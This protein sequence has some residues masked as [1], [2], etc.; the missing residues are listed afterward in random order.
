MTE[1]SPFSDGILL[2]F[3]DEICV[4]PP[5][6]NLAKW[7]RQAAARSLLPTE[8][9]I[10]QCCQTP[11]SGTSQVEIWHRPNK[12]ATYH[13]LRRCGSVWLCAVC[14][15]KIALTR[16]A[17]LH[18]AVDAW[19][20]FGHHLYMVTFTMQHDSEDT[21]KQLRTCLKIALREVRS[22]KAYQVVK[23]EWGILGAFTGTEVTHGT[24]GWHIHAHQILFCTQAVDKQVMHDW[25]YRQWSS[26]LDKLYRYAT[27]ENGIKVSDECDTRI[28]KYVTKWGI[29]SEATMANWKTGAG[30]NPWQLLDKAFF[31][32]KFS[33]KLWL[34]YANGSK[35][36]SKASW[37]RGM[38]KL[39]K[40]TDLTDQEIVDRLENDKD[41]V[42]LARIP[43]DHWQ[44]ILANDARGEILEFAKQGIDVLNQFL[45]TM[46]LSEI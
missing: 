12:Y 46:G 13:K 2:V 36:M 8:N 16:R 19:H 26:A 29:E 23:S 42:L 22:G 11:I 10:H 35:G 7:T 14:S 40:V 20:D 21:F 9:R 39:F 44:V 17:E 31:Q 28:N 33:A 3:N 45:A 18:Q 25:F 43:Y 30:L 5:N 32:D 27:P 1:A 6:P 24:N 4:T 38:K 41:L 15:A 37:S 34:E